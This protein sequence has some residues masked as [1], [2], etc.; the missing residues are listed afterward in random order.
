[1]Q[2]LLV[3]GMAALIGA[4]AIGAGVASAETTPAPAPVP[5]TAPVPPLG[6]PATLY[7]KAVRMD[8]SLQ[9]TTGFVFDASLNGV[10]DSMPPKLHAFLEQVLDGEIFSIDTTTAKCFAD[11]GTTTKA[12]TCQQVADYIDASPDAV[13]ATVL[14]RAVPGSPL[15]FVAKKLIAHIDVLP[16][17]NASQTVR[18]DVSLAFAS[19]D[20]TFDATLNSVGGNVPDRLVALLEKRLDGDFQIDASRAICAITSSGSAQRSLC[21]D[22]A[23]LVNGSS[24]NVSATVIGRLATAGDGTLTFVATKLIADGDTATSMSDA[25][26]SGF[27]GTS[28]GGTS[29]GHGDDDHR[30]NDHNGVGGPLSHRG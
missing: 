8:V 4:A 15:D 20:S 6:A 7:K 21:A 16:A 12:V 2:R 9:D 5:A 18:L 19:D 25:G 13:T 23:D 28:F 24:D 26:R 14:A 22:V 11:D 1:M 30:N 17:L 10:A 29:L 3:A 27:G